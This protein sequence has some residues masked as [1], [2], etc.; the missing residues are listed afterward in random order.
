LLKQTIKENPY[1]DDFPQGRDFAVLA[2]IERIDDT[3]RRYFVI[4]TVI[5]DTAKL[6]KKGS[7]FNIECI[8]DITVI[9]ITNLQRIWYNVV[10]KVLWILRKN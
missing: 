7:Y 1:N 2:E 6:F 10:A 9:P 3:P 5:K 8:G 4:K